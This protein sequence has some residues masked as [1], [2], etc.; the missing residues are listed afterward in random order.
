M[1]GS[2]ANNPD[3]IGY[4]ITSGEV[5]GGSNQG[6]ADRRVN[7]I[8]YDSD[9]TFPGGDFTMELDLANRSFVMEHNGE[10]ITIDDQIG[11]F[12]YSPIVYIQGTHHPREGIHPTE[13]TLL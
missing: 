12:E 5:F 7:K 2:R 11:D 10:K 6:K 1:L 9:G 8:E 13:I 3:I 4:Y